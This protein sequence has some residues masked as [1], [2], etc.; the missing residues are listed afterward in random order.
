MMR[1]FWF[2]STSAKTSTSFTLAQSASS[3]MW[4]ISGPVMISGRSPIA[5]LMF[6]AT[7]RL[8][9]VNIFRETPCSL[10]FFTVSA[11][12]GFSG[13]YRATKPRKV[14]PASSSRVIVLFL[15][16]SL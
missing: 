10:S 12:P 9:P 11:M 7:S 8:S 3:P 15:P 16:M 5:L 6:A 1:S 2:G 4:Y 14:I 13:S